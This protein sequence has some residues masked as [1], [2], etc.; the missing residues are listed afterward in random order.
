MRYFK[1]KTRFFLISITEIPLK[2][3]LLITFVDIFILKIGKYGKK[4][5]EKLRK[6][7]SV[8]KIVKN[9]GVYL[10][11]SKK[12]YFL[13][14]LE[15][16]KKFLNGTQ[17]LE[18]LSKI[19]QLLGPEFSRSVNPIRTRVG[20]FCPSHYCLPPGF[21]KLS[22]TLISDCLFAVL[23]FPIIQRRNLMNFFPRI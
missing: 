12:P 10:K 3:M 1:H 14:F 18:N 7:G 4:S 11:L 15:K 16:K 23:N 6:L 17:A 5:V 9:W 8:T 13:T 22:T 19:K 21:K 2:V 20:K